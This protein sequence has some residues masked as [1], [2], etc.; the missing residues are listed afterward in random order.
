MENPPAIEEV[1]D[2]LR[3]NDEQPNLRE[4]IGRLAMRKYIDRMV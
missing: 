2:T 3:E 4:I 1:D